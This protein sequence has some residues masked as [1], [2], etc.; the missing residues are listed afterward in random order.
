MRT[1]MTHLADIIRDMA[2]LTRATV[3][4]DVD[5]ESNEEA[6]AESVD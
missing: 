3:D 1:S 4:E 5:A 6:Y 2:Q